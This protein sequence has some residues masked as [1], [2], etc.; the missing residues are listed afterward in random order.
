MKM[1][2]HGTK[3]L[4]LL[5]VLLAVAISFVSEIDVATATPNG[6]TSGLNFFTNGIDKSQDDTYEW[7]DIYCAANIPAGSTGVILEL[8]SGGFG[9]TMGVREKGSTD[10]IT[11][12]LDASDLRTVFVGVDSDRKFQVF[13]SHTSA[14]CKI[15]LIGYTDVNVG[16]FTNVVDKTPSTTGSWQDVDVSGNIPSGSTGVIMLL[17]NT[18]TSDY[19]AGG[20]RKKGSTD[21]ITYGRI[22]ADH[23]ISQLCGVDANRVFQAKIETTYTKVYLVGYTKKPVDFLTNAVDKTPGGYQ[24]WIDVDVTSETSSSADGAILF[25]QNTNDVNPYTAGV[26]KKGS[27]DELQGYLQLSETRGAAIGMDTSQIFQAR[28]QTAWLKVFIIGYAEPVPLSIGEYE[29]PSTAYANKYFFLNATVN[30][31]TAKTKFVNATLQISTVVLKWDNATNTFSEHS[32]PSNYCILNVSAS[33]RSDVN[34]TAYKLSWN[35]RL[36]WTYPEGQVT[37]IGNVI[38]D[39]SIQ[40][41]N[42]KSNVFYFEE[43]L[44]IYSASVDDSHV[45]PSQMLNFTGTV[46]YQGTTDPPENTTGITAKVKLSET[47]KGSTTTISAA[48]VFYINFTAETTVEN[49]TYTVLTETDQESVQNQDV[50][51]TVDKLTVIFTANEYY[52]KEDVTVI[53]SWAITRQ[54]DGSTVTNFTIDVSRDTILWKDDTNASSTTDIRSTVGDYTY[55]VYPSTI[56]DNTYNLTTFTSS[57][58]TVHWLEKQEL[59]PPQQETP[60]PAYVPPP[61]N[62]IPPPTPGLLD[63]IINYLTDLLQNRNFYIALAVMLVFVAAVYIKKRRS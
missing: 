42:T 53:I 4:T 45:D 52:P 2:R 1:R 3:T 27:I 12:W 16:L 23:G 30:H 22:Y 49:H 31:E 60:P 61:P 28:I 57:P 13:Q 39:D 54:Y 41:Q 17:K 48:G 26:R 35:L 62:T 36:N 58:C 11:L 33:E 47:T 38:D 59:N 37:V 24:A 19:T 9:V 51:A 32:D 7:V 55:D 15:Y 46:Y 18:W 43:D 40:V 20:I 6:G 25:L 56:T 8:Q 21:E 44:I 29:A 34:A 63:R 5:L 50:H 10:T 14:Y